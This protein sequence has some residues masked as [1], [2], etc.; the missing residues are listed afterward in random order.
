MKEV[1]LLLLRVISSS[2]VPASLTENYAE[3][4]GAIHATDHSNMYVNGE[5]TI[6]YNMAKNTGGGVY[7]DTSEIHC[8]SNSSIN[9]SS[10]TATKKGGGVHAIS[11]SINVIG[12][13]TYYNTSA[14][15]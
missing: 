12:N 8:Q 1:P 15:D 14:D 6:A 10:N 11:S 7:L 4:G 9:I 2:I 3:N 5:I 13:F